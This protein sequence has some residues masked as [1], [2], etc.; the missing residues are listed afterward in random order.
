MTYDLAMR[1]LLF[2]ILTS[3]SLCLSTINNITFYHEAL[4]QSIQKMAYGT[5]ERKLYMIGGVT[6]GESSLQTSLLTYNS[7]SNY[8]NTE[9][10]PAEQFDFELRFVS[11]RCQI[12]SNVYFLPTSCN[13]GG[14]YFCYNKDCSI[15]KVSLNDLS[16]TKLTP[17]LPGAN[18][19]IPRGSLCGFIANTDGLEYLFKVGGQTNEWGGVGVKNTYLY[20][21][22]ASSWSRMSDLVT[23]VSEATCV[24]YND[25]LYLFSGRQTAQIQ[26]YDLKYNQWS[27][28][29]Q[30]MGNSIMD[31][32][33]II[34]EPY[35]LIFG[36]NI[37]RSTSVNYHQTSI[38]WIQIYDTQTDILTLSTSTL[39]YVTSSAAITYDN[40]TGLIYIIG[41]Q[42]QIHNTLG[43]IQIGCFNCTEQYIINILP[44]PTPPPTPTAPPTANV[45]IDSIKFTVE[46]S[47]F[48]PQNVSSMVYGIYNEKIVMIGGVYV[49]DNATGDHPQIGNPGWP[50]PSNSFISNN[51]IT[52]DLKTNIFTLIENNVPVKFEIK[53]PSYYQ[54]DNY[55]YYSVQNCIDS[56]CGNGGTRPFW[57]F[58]FIDETFEQLIDVP[59]GYGFATMCGIISSMDNLPYIYSIGGVSNQQW[60]YIYDNNIYNIS[61]Q[62]WSIKTNSPEH[63]L[64]GV[65]VGVND[66]LYLFGGVY[67]NKIIYYNSINDQWTISQQTIINNSYQPVDLMQ[68]HGL[69]LSDLSYIL[70][71]GGTDY[72]GSGDVSDMIRVY[73]YNNDIIV[74]LNSTMS[75]PMT[76]GTM[77]LDNVTNI[78]YSLGGVKQNIDHGGMPTN[79]WSI[80]CIY[81]SIFNTNSSLCKGIINIPETDMPTTS[82]TTIEPSEPIEWNISAFF[83]DTYLEIYVDLVNN[84]NNNDIL[85]YGNLDKCDEIFSINSTDINLLKGAKCVFVNNNQINNIDII[86]SL[87][88]LSTIV[89]NND[90]LILNS[91]SFHYFRIEDNFQNQHDVINNLLFYIKPAINPVHP[92]IDLRFASIIGSCDEMEVDARSTIHLGVRNANFTWIV[93]NS[94]PSN[95]NDMLPSILLSGLDQNILSNINIDISSTVEIQLIVE[96]WFGEYSI[97]IFNITKLN[98]ALPVL[99][100]TATP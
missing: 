80:G 36:G 67:T 74:N 82:T 52:F 61:N 20:N 57:R 30:S 23:A 87:S 60:N 93:L 45:S 40:E 5:Y 38:D 41:G 79:Q 64:Q 29:T 98:D 7:T 88:S 81:G 63:M 16:F 26:I 11:M 84:N 19:G 43:K 58:N 51:M 55:L 89:P 99:I 86:I 21:E 49:E 33:T 42:R 83:S 1:C 9:P 78:I 15:W 12:G 97:Q 31:V 25:K 2:T 32:M 53:S 10:P 54:I 8:I 72:H 37:P 70:L 75:Y 69:I 94:Y 90:Q 76:L 6:A 77:V 28:S 39:P 59:T 35:I 13:V 18:D 65:C 73:D 22:S 17:A 24:G 44:P 68:M 92:L 96:S 50:Y 47:N 100:L 91:E 56:T 62:T 14:C 4:L 46:T 66:M 95:T 85:V 34:M 27:L 71:F 48:M 3:I